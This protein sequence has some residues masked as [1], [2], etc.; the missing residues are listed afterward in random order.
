[1]FYIL[2]VNYYTQEYTQS[3]RNSAVM[4]TY[5]YISTVYFKLTQSSVNI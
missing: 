4:S 1:M 3:Q 2:S 5:R